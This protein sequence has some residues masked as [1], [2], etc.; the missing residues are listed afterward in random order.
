MAVR[1]PLRVV[2][3]NEAPPA[4]KRPKTVTEAAKNGTPRELLVAMRDRVAVAVE[5]P[6]TAARDLASL[7]KRLREIALDIESIDLRARE[8][9]SDAEDVAADEAWN[10]AAL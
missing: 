8:E 10:A 6:N 9:G 5:N 2:A 4:P 1:K 3:P 7:T